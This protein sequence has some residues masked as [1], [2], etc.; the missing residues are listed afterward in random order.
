M[1]QRGSYSPWKPQ[2][3]RLVEL[4]ALPNGSTGAPRIVRFAP[5][6]AMYIVTHV[7]ANYKHPTERIEHGLINANAVSVIDAVKM[8]LI[9]TVRLDDA[10]RGA[11]NPWGR[12]LHS[13]RRISLHHPCRDARIKHHRP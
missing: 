9:A 2:P 11:A 12:A 1:P 5:T 4:I 6:A 7:L 8:R 13:G 3:N 10:D